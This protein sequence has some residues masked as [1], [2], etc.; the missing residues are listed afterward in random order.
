[1][2]KTKTTELSC[3]SGARFLAPDVGSVVMWQ[4]RAVKR[5]P[6]KTKAY[7]DIDGTVRMTD[8][9]RHISWELWSGS[10]EGWVKNV[11]KLDNA[12]IELERARDHLRWVGEKAGYK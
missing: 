6:P 9:A 3:S 7:T 1:M 4:V 10:H 2:S 11:R 8:C 12:I 5:K